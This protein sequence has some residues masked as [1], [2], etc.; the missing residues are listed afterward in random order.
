MRKLIMQ[1]YIVRRPGIASTGAELNAALT[2]LRAFEDES[3]GLNARWMRSYALRE[4]NGRFGLACVFEA[5]SV[6]TLMVHALKTGVKAQEILPVTA[7]VIGRRLAPMMVYLIRRRNF[8]HTTEDF[9]RSA[10]VSRFVGEE[11]F[12]GDVKWLR[13]YA[14]KENDGTVGAVGLYQAVHADALRRHSVRVGVPA[15][16][17]IPVLG[18][19]VF[20]EEA[21]SPAA[22]ASTA[23][24]A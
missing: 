20:R 10:A 21:S 11:E 19:I 6:Q 2:R 16:E 17:I 9:E 13:T 15:D 4:A 18:H 23:L 24:A 22:A 1:N 8:W 14:I 3:S 7:T 5:D 12:S